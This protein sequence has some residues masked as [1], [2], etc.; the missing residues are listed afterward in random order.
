VDKTASILM[1]LN[2]ASYHAQSKRCQEL[3]VT[4]LLLKPVDLLELKQTLLSM[5]S[6]RGIEPARPDPLQIMHSEPKP[7]DLKSRGTVFPAL[8]IPGLDIL[9]V[10]DNAVNQQVA[11]RVLEKRGHRVQLA[12]NGRKAIS[13]VQQANFDVVLMDIQMPQMSGYEATAAIRRWEATEA[14]RIPIIAMTAHAMSGIRQRCL[15]AGMDGYVSKP[16]KI[17]DLLNEIDSILERGPHTP[18]FDTESLLQPAQ[19]D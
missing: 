14:K 12:E 5:L 10:E 7:L 2:A 4:A 11:K 3:D 1:M 9:L 17:A 6:G 19:G 13:A 8:D 15:E 18:S 16:L